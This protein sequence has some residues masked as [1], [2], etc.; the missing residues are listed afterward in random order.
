MQDK[1]RLL[2]GAIDMFLFKEVI[3]MT[4]QKILHGKISNMQ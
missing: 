4:A 3:I 1:R 2:L